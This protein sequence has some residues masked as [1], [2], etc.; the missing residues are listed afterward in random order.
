MNSHMSEFT[1][2][3]EVTER[4]HIHITRLVSPRRKIRV[5]FS[6]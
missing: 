1:L 2:D 6:D 5:E 4:I 3:Q